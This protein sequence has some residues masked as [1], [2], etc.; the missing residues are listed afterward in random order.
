MLARELAPLYRYENCV[1][2]AL[3]DGG[4]LVGSEIAAALHAMLTLLVI[5]DIEIP[6]ENIKFGGVSQDGNFT[7][8]S[9]FSSGEVEEYVSEFHGYL[10]DQKREVF[11]KINRL[12]GDGGLVDHEML[13][14]QTVIL[15]TD[16]IDDT[17]IIDVAVDFL[18]PIRIEKLV[19][20]VPVVSVPAVDKLHLAADELHI[21]DVKQNFMG[22]QHYYEDNELPSH[23][24]VIARINQI[25]LNW[26]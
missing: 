1:V 9:S 11:Q 10:E 17:T 25:I 6:G 21:L 7:Y 24:E 5:E 13:R 12:L 8:N 15:V 20:A 14:D 23:E 16:G 3:S 4:V 19:A 2:L 22:T 18:K 26:R